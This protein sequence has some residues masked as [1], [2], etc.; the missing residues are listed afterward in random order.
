MTYFTSDEEEDEGLYEASNKYPGDLEEDEREQGLERDL[1]EADAGRKQ[2]VTGA[3]AAV[4]DAE[5]I[6][7]ARAK[8]GG[9]EVLG[10]GSRTHR[11][12]NTKYGSKQLIPM[13]SILAKN[14][15]SMSEGKGLRIKALADSGSSASIIS[16]ESENLQPGKGMD[17]DGYSSLVST[18]A[19]QKHV[20]V[21]GGEEEPGAERKAAVR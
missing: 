1:E 9:T 13:D 15:I 12:Y 5:G 17:E 7:G 4:D 3:G 18:E 14:I 16:L 6:A 10:G 11:V 21:H 19:H 20:K 2:I 8:D